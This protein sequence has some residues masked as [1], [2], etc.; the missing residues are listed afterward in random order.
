M[1][2]PVPSGLIQQILE[3]T[4]LHIVDGGGRLSADHASLVQYL[5]Q[6]TFFQS[7]LEEADLETVKE[8]ARC[9]YTYTCQAGEVTPT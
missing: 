5:L 3:E 7:L 2:E 4:A 8:C 1:K 9:I 6:L